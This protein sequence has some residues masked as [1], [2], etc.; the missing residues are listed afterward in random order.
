MV[1]GYVAYFSG[2]PK[3][4]LPLS[5]TQD[6]FVVGIVRAQRL[7]HFRCLATVCNGAG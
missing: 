3:L 1:Q 5:Q 7:S 4:N 2:I 6:C